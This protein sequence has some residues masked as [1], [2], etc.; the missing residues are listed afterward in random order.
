MSIT[1]QTKLVPRPGRVD[2]HTLTPQLKS[3]TPQLKGVTPQLKMCKLKRHDRSPTVVNNGA[4][5]VP[6][7]GRLGQ[8]A[9][10]HARPRLRFRVQGAGFR[11]QGSG[12]RAQGAGF[13]VQ[14]SGLRAQGA[15]FR[16]QGSECRVQ[17]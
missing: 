4:A 6:G 13:K 9:R 10:P 14:G 11:V 7:P 8:R 5:I 2:Q 17:G 1:V 12:F 15:G 16:V 3:V